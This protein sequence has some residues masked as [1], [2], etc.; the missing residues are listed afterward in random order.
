MHILALAVLL[1]A[2]TAEP[3]ATAPFPPLAQS[4]LLAVDGGR[5]ADALTLRIH[6]PADPAALTPAQ[7]TEVAVMSAGR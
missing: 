7:L 4:A 1:A 6:R 2:A 3:A 5:A